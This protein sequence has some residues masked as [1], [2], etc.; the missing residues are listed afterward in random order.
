MAVHEPLRLQAV[1][2]LRRRAGFSPI[3]GASVA[4][5]TPSPSAARA[6]AVSPTGESP[7]ASSGVLKP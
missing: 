7:L 5:G 4:I 2:E 6:R 1:K 3:A